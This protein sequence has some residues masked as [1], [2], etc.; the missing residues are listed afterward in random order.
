MTITHTL[1]RR[2][3]KKIDDPPRSKAAAD[4]GNPFSPFSNQLDAILHV[5]C[6]TDPTLTRRHVQAFLWALRQIGV[7]NVPSYSHVCSLRDLVPK[8]VIKSAE[9]ID[10]RKGLFYFVPPS[11]TVKYFAVD[12]TVFPHLTTLPRQAGGAVHDFMDTPRA[13]ELFE[14]FRVANIY[15]N[16]HLYFVDDL[17]EWRNAGN[18]ST[19]IGRIIRLERPSWDLLGQDSKAV[20]VTLRECTWMEGKLVVLPSDAIEILQYDLIRPLEVCWQH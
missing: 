7:K 12:P 6:N 15:Q 14:S 20:I 9:C 4:T 11:E 3:Y 19:R 5:L 8:P 13:R 10:G 18:G 16:E 17:V 1:T 2:H